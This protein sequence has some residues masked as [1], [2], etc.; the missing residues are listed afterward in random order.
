MKTYRYRL[1]PTPKQRAALNHTLD[2]C[3]DLY[4]CALE[5]RRG[6]RI[7]QFEQMRQLTGLKSEFTEYETVHA[8]VLQNVIKKLDRSFQNFFR[9]C[10]KGGTPGYPRFRGRGRY[11]SFAFNNVGFKLSGKRLQI[12]KIGSIKVRLSRPVEGEIKT[13]TL[14]RS[15]GNWYVSLTTKYVPTPLP[16]STLSV[17]IDV[18]IENFAALSSGEMIPSPRLYENAQAELRKAQRRVARRKKGSHGRRAA[19]VLLRKVH[20]RI[21]NRRT[22]FIHKQSTT[23]VQRY[24]RIAIEKLNVGGLARG[25]LSKQVYDT[26]WATFFNFLSY[27]AEWAGREFVEVDASYTSQTCPNCG[28]IKKKSLSERKHQC[29][30]CGHAAHRDTAAAQVIL[31]RAFPSGVNVGDR[32]HA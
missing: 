24:G 4:N 1:N 23:L 11:D 14:K 12:S 8:H 7:S 15:S 9:R 26:G 30:E 29:L 10:K 13:C 21:Q 27:K 22:D 32:P 17:G 19:V 2:L 25:I 16:S 20:E 6:Q 28:N 31:G 3:R 5:Q 18:G